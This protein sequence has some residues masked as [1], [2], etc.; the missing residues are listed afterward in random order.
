MKIGEYAN[1]AFL[2]QQ[3]AE[4]SLKALLLFHQR[5]SRTHSCVDILEILKK[6]RC[7]DISRPLLSKAKKL[8]R[9]YINSRYPNGLGGEPGKY[10][11]QEFAEEL[12]QCAREV[13]SF[14]QQQLTAESG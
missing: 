7:L 13:M 4:K 14:A 12:I 5:H 9:Q 6:E 1:V 3:A 2:S 11:D 10:Y 8:D